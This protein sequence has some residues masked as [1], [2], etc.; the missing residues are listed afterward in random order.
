MSVHVGILN[1]DMEHWSKTANYFS[2]GDASSYSQSMSSWYDW[3]HGY[4]QHPFYLDPQA[5]SV[6]MQQQQQQLHGYTNT[7]SVTDVDAVGGVA[8][9]AGAQLQYPTAAA[10]GTGTVA[11][12]GGYMTSMVASDVSSMMQQ[13]YDSTAL[14]QVLSPR[15]SD[16]AL[17]QHQKLAK[18]CNSY[19][20]LGNLEEEFQLKDCVGIGN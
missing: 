1:T 2:C 19:S 12:A 6:A 18:T 16:A 17:R 3:Y 8:V 10:G 5:S 20:L 4:Q 9:A 13:L 7:S 15:V 11:A 14:A